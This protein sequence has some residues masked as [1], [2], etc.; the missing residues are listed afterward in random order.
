MP[1]G[2]ILCFGPEAGRRADGAVLK[3]SGLV[4][5]LLKHAYGSH[6]QRLVLYGDP[7]YGETGVILAG[8]KQVKKLGELEQD[9]NNEM[10]RFR[11]CAEWSFGKV[12]VYCVRVHL[13]ILIR[14]LLKG[15]QSVSSL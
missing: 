14:I 10:S 13:Q 8:R 15:C 4:A 2:I 3:E 7:A 11:E 9:L 12:C 6:G 1:N 5:K